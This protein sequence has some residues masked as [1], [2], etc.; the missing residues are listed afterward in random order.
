[1]RQ[2]RKGSIALLIC[3]ATPALA[4]DLPDLTLTPGVVATT[5][6]AIVCNTKWGLDRRHVTAAM[7]REVFARYGLSG[8]DDKSCKLDKY[9]RR[10]EIDHSCP[11]DLG[12]A[13]AIENLWP[14]CYSG[15]WNAAMKDR[16]EIRLHK[17]VCAGSILLEDAQRD[18]AK[19]DWRVVYRRYF[20]GK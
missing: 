13:D 16:L 9:G 8:N 5:S 14:Q 4:R 2:W 17:E 10:F 12:C 11:R 7:R 1:M 15:R 6:R 18:I 19:K 3:L 20:G